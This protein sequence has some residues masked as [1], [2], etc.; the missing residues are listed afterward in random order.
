[1]VEF[2]SRIYL[3]S[4]EFENLL[5]SFALNMLNL[6]TT[7]CYSILL[8]ALYFGELWWMT[9]SGFGGARTS[10]LEGFR[11]CIHKSVSTRVSWTSVSAR[12]FS[13]SVPQG[14]LHGNV[15]QISRNSWV[16]C[17]HSLQGSENEQNWKSSVRSLLHSPPWMLRRFPMEIQLT[18]ARRMDHHKIDAL[19]GRL[20]KMQS[21]K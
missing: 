5:W 18:R 10:L 15:L 9:L 19:K 14:H 11:K 3:V 7:D 8:Y 1:M 2:C 16:L 20:G 17:K 6:Y 4:P 12:G 21:T 13:K